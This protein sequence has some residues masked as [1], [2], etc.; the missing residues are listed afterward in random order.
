MKKNTI[1]IICILF[2]LFVITS[3]SDNNRIINATIKCSNFE[4]VIVN[5]DV[6]TFTNGETK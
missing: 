2:M 1:K 5:N 4:I 3:C 6:F